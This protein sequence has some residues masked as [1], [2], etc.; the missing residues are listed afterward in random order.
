MREREL[1]RADASY[2]SA[3]ATSSGMM[4]LH[5]TTENTSVKLYVLCDRIE[6]YGIGDS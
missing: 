4:L 2:G 5:T 3:A 1:V 6:R